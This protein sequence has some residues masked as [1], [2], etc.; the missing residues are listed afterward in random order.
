MVPLSSQLFQKPL[1]PTVVE[2]HRCLAWLAGQADT[3]NK[4]RGLD[5]NKAASILAAP[6]RHLAKF[7]R[8]GS[9]TYGSTQPTGDMDLFCS[10]KL[11]DVL[12][13]IYVKIGRTWNAS[14][15]HFPAT[16]LVTFHFHDGSIDIHMGGIQTILSMDPAEQARLKEILANER[17]ARLHVVVRQYMEYQ[18]VLFIP[19]NRHKSRFIKRCYQEIESRPALF[20]VLWL[21]SGRHHALPT[22]FL[23]VIVHLSLWY[24]ERVVAELL[25]EL[26]GGEAPLSPEDRAA[27]AFDAALQCAMALLARTW[28]L[29]FG[30]NP[31]DQEARYLADGVFGPFR[32]GGAW[33]ERFDAEVLPAFFE[34]MRASSRFGPFFVG[35]HTFEELFH[36]TLSEFQRDRF[37]RSKFELPGLLAS[38]LGKDG[39]LR[40]G[41][42]PAVKGYA[43]MGV[44]MSFAVVAA[45]ALCY[46]ALPDLD[47]IRR[48]LGYGTRARVACMLQLLQLSSVSATANDPT[49]RAWPVDPA[50][51]FGSDVVAML[52]PVLN[53]ALKVGPSAAALATL[54]GVADFAISH[55][56]TMRIDLPRDDSAGETVPLATCVGTSCVGGVPVHYFNMS[57]VPLAQY[58]WQAHHWNLLSRF[59]GAAVAQALFGQ[60][61]NDEAEIRALCAQ[62]HL[63]LDEKKNRAADTAAASAASTDGSN[64]DEA[65]EN[66]KPAA[67]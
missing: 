24:G 47:V 49:K 22:F 30:S 21:L 65:D 41:Q 10:G 37:L 53:P 16:N 48:M 63:S 42:A 59:Q 3:M 12:E 20:R 6:G 64:P 40:R 67:V 61:W 43:L 39:M 9:S 2:L 55:M 32:P 13:G 1:D 52:S 11:S 17:M 27:V 44:P 23:A 25:S 62:M 35:I 66:P 31:D 8:K 7:Y 15:F 19:N 46:S 50:L 36:S 26:P 56:W 29:W 38:L 57:Y 18:G 51:L 28:A 5:C 4:G 45:S 60:R 33:A 34:K 58:G 54:Q 14:G